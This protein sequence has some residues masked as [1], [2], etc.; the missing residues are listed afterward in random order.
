MTATRIE[1]L[2]EIVDQVQ[3]D[4]SG[5]HGHCWVEITEDTC[6]ADICDEIASEILDGGKETCS[7]YVASNGQHYR[8]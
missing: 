7:D 8:W 1:K 4:K 5:G 6:G 2:Y 3:W